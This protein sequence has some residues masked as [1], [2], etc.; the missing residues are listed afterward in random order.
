MVNCL[1]DLLA[2]KP[3]QEQN[4]LKLMVNKLGDAENKVAA[5]SSQKLNELMVQH[6]GMKMYVV[7]EIEQLLLR[8][9]NTQRTQY[10]AVITLNQTI[11][12]G[13]DSGVANKLVELYF[14]FFR[15]LMKLTEDE[16]A[17]RENQ[18]AAEPEDGD[19]KKGDPKARKNK[20]QLD[21][22]K[23]EAQRQLEVDE[24]N[25]KMIAAIL[26]GVNRA[27]HFTT[28]PDEL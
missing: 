1:H 16:D 11:L 21:R 19:N 14:S 24:Y 4:L 15:R 9:N 25:S 27:F 13:K 10:Y 7:R 20:K 22:E 3:E 17:S 6:P 8:P 26:T 28:L 2:G 23:K 5:K 12:T 18:D